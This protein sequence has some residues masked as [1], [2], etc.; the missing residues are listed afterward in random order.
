MVLVVRFALLNRR[1]NR[2]RLGF[3]ENGAGAC[4]QDWRMPVNQMA[5]SAKVPVSVTLSKDLV[6]EACRL[7]SDLSG[8]VETLLATYVARERSRRIEEQRAVDAAI[9]ATNDYVARHGL[10]GEDYLPV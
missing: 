9:A 1:A 2:Y 5:H 10:P 4:R 6:Q 8:T 3:R 7:T